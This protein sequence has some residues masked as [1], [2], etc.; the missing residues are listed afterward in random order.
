MRIDQWYIHIVYR[1]DTKVSDKVYKGGYEV[2]RHWDTFLEELLSEI[3]EEYPEAE[4][5]AMGV[6][7]ETI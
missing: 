7:K 2:F 1:T 6:Y 5:L 4:I 3:F